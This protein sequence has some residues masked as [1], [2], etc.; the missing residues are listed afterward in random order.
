MWDKTITAKLI[1]DE[2][3]LVSTEGGS[4]GLG[5]EEL[6]EGDQKVQYSAYKINKS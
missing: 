1:G 3:R 2:I 5:V 6:E 4:G